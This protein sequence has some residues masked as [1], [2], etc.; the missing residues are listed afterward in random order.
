MRISKKPK[1]FNLKRLLS[2]RD[3]LIEAAEAVRNEKSNCLEDLKGDVKGFFEQIFGFTPFKYQV[4]LAK[5]FE[6]N[7]FTA[8]R[9]A[10]QTGKSSSVSALLLKYAVEHPESYIAI[11]GPSWRQTKL[12]VKRI[13]GFCRKLPEPQG[14]Q[15]YKMAHRLL[16]QQ[17][18][19]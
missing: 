10:R 2:E 6:E 19:L 15:V 18:S 8:V 11:V 12:N 4:E 7:Q 16:H 1:A 13:G 9:W 17:P 14:L 5:L 3:K